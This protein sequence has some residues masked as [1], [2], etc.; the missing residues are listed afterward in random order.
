MTEEGA[1]AALGRVAGEGEA[2]PADHVE[3]RV[4]S[5]EG[6]RAVDR[7][8]ELAPD[9][10]VERAGERVGIEVGAGSAGVWA[11]AEHAVE[12]V[13]EPVRGRGLRSEER[14]VGKECKSRC[15]M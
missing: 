10:R 15:A 8:Q 6:D 5:A 3:G 14:R 4:R 9:P 13:G 12:T 1:A 11:G 2:D 7:E